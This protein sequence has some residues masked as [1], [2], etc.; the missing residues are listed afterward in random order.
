MNDDELYDELRPWRTV[1][2]LAA[3][4][5]VSLF[6]LRWVINKPLLDSLLALV[7]L[8]GIIV[9]FGLCATGIVAVTAFIGSC[10]LWFIGLEKTAKSARDA[11]AS[12]SMMSILYT[13]C[14]AT[15]ILFLAFFIW[16]IF[17]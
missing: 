1:I 5:A 9:F 8:T 17:G 4:V 2:L 10:V 13:A 16:K 12:D 14:T 6:V 11:L 15:P 7:F 3:Y